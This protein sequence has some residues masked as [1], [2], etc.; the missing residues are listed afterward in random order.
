MIFKT[1]LALSAASLATAQLVPTGP[2]PGDSFREGGQCL[3]QF[4]PD[5]SSSSSSSGISAWKDTTI[6]LMSGSNLDMVKV[7]DIVTG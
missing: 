2:T 6:S 4:T 5:S 3:I 7:V 1:A